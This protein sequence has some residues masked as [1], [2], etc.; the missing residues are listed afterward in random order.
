MNWADYRRLCDR[1]DVVS[2]FLLEQT[3]ELIGS[4]SLS[5]RLN[6][7]LAST[8]IEKPAGHRGPRAS[9]MFVAD[10]DVEAVRAIAVEVERAVAGGRTTSGTRE[11][12]LGGFL[13]AWREM[14]RFLDDN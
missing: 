12:G 10:L 4:G 2:R 11:R 3:A 6:T 9:D 14:G 1:P 8:P 13:E 7:L 5:E